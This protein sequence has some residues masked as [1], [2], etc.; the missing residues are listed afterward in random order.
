MALKLFFIIKI[1]ISI[2]VVHSHKTKQLK[3]T[4]KIGPGGRRH[5]VW[6]KEISDSES[7][8]ANEDEQY[9]AAMRG[10]F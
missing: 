8:L 1:S 9:A 2:P 7:Y 3:M 4:K 6:L 10:V 5:P